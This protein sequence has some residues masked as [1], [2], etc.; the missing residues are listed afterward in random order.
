MYYKNNLI[1]LQVTFNAN[2]GHFDFNQH[3]MNIKKKN[4]Q[5][6]IKMVHKNVRN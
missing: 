4:Q 3:F 6:V 1:D 5:Q 2:D